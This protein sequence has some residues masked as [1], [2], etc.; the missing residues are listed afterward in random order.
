MG[1][2]G[3]EGVGSGCHGDWKRI[4]SVAEIISRC[5][6]QASSLSHYYS[7]IAPQVS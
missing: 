2:L 1:L 3:E 5:P 4:Q 7:I 6:S